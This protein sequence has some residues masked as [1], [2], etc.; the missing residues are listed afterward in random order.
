[1]TVTTSSTFATPWAANPHLQSELEYT[2]VFELL[3]AVLPRRRPPT[4][5]VNKA[6]RRL[7]VVANT[8]AKMLAL[9]RSRVDRA[10]PHGRPVPSNYLNEAAPRIETRRILV[11]RHGGGGALARGARRR[12]LASGARRPTWCSTSPS[13]SRRWRSTRTSS[14]SPTEPAWRRP[15]T[16][17]PS[18]RALPR[19]CRRATGR[20]APLVDPASAATS[21]VARAR[22]RCPQCAVARWCGFGDKTPAP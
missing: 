12:C 11:E 5:S 18:S 7:F 9:R 6:T 20:R 13:A 8:P 15:G 2:S 17:S 19:G 16:R 3:A 14:A 1:M 10:H 22:T 21:A 4:S